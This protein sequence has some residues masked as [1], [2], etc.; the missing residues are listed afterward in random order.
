MLA[1]HHDTGHIDAEHLLKYVHIEILSRELLVQSLGVDQNV[2]LPHIPNDRIHERF[3]ALLVRG[4]Y[5]IPTH[6]LVTGLL[7]FSRR[8]PEG[9]LPPA[10]YRY[11]GTGL[12]KSLCDRLAKP[13]GTAYY[14]RIFTI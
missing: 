7:D 2:Y 3:N 14:H 9:L 1:A 8:A 6:P 5:G 11:L 13:S 4:I 12:S 10:G